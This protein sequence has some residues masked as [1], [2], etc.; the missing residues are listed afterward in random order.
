MQTRFMRGYY[1]GDRK[2]ETVYPADREDTKGQ[3]ILPAKT[4]TGLWNESLTL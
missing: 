3:E 4:D 2:L 1:A